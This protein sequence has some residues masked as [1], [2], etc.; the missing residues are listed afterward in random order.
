MMNSRSCPFPRTRLALV[1]AAIPV[2]GLPLVGLPGLA[3]AVPAENSDYNTDEAR[4][5]VSE[6]SADVFGMTNEILC[7]IKQ[8]RYEMMVN[9]GAY[10]AQ[11]DAGQC[12]DDK[13]DPSEAASSSQNQSSGG[14]TPEYME[15]TVN[16]TRASDT[17]TQYLNAWVHEEGGDGPEPAMLIKARVAI[18]ES[19]SDSNPVGIFKMDFQGFMV[20]ENGQP[21]AQDMMHGYMEVAE[22]SNNND[23]PVLSFYDTSTHPEGQEMTM[24]TWSESAVL[25]KNLDGS[26]VGKTSTD[27]NS[28]FE[29]DSEF[30]LAFNATH[31]KR[32]DGALEGCFSR[33]DFD[34]TAWRYA[35]YDADTGT[36]V[37]LES[38]FPIKVT[39]GDESFHGWVG[40]WGVWMPEEVTLANGA[41]VLRQSFDNGE[42]EETPYTIVK[43]GGKLIRVTR[44]S[45]TLDDVAGVPIDWFNNGNNAQ[46]VWNKELQQLQKV[47]VMQEGDGMFNWVDVEGGPVALTETDMGEFFDFNGFARSLGGNVRF[48]LRNNQ[49]QYTAPSGTTETSVFVE[50]TVFPG[51]TT[52][53]S[54]SCNDMC[55]DA[56]AIDSTNPMHGNMMGP[57]D[58]TYTYTF[59][60]STML[61]KEGSTA[62]VRTSSSD[63]GNFQWGFHSGPLYEA[64][65]ANMAKL[66][67][68]WDAERVCGWKAWQELDEFFT[69]ETGTNNW[70]Q[71][72]LLKDAQNQVLTFD[73]PLQVIF[74]TPNTAA[75]TAL[76][77]NASKLM[78]EYQGMGNLQG[79]PGQ[80]VDPETNEPASCGEN[81]RWVPQFTVPDG[82]VLVNASNENTQY[83][84]KALEKEQR[85][86]K[87]ADAQC[88]SLDLDAA[89][90]LTLPDGS[91]YT[92]PGIGDEPTVTDAPAVIGGEMQVQFDD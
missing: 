12:S 71:L 47:R 31:F 35:M 45:M 66:A 11:V 17:A 85:M 59:D 64:T 54:L 90:A 52:P 92:A 74:T 19:A 3:W 4:V 37:S 69:W 43:A 48:R 15:W 44:K 67:C 84:V 21:V 26:G 14:D 76:G 41:T 34:E 25:R 65:E 61:L 87:V 29:P 6:R 13:D 27:S 33:T 7:M 32:D 49:N 56:S 10:R 1:L 55:P 62:V 50:K 16:V 53:A 39:Q 77:Y 23:Q 72:V 28:Q 78:L 83:L 91:A 20:G 80:C 51:E 40:Y 63:S 81:K 36:R 30:A 73:P 5:Y 9:R 68:D 24:V 46:V 58:T 60:G 82:S 89:A 79:I 38:G 2:V 8:T 42:S 70:N 57:N 75:F 88:T 86:G 18:T 22:D